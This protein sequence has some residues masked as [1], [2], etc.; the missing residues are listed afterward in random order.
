MYAPSPNDLLNVWERGTNKPAFQKALLLLGVAFPQE[1]PDGLAQLS[2]G[3]RN[4]RLLNLREQL[5]GA[6]FQS[7]VTCPRCSECLDLSFK[8]VD[9]RA[10]PENEPAESLALDV[11]DYAMRF[12]LPTS[13]DLATV[14]GCEDAAA[15]RRA[16]LERCLLSA[17]RK[18]IA[19]TVDDLPAEVLK[20]IDE[21]MEE[22]DPQ[23]NTQLSM[24]CP[25]CGYHWQAV[26]DLVTYVWRELDAW[27]RRALREVH[28]LAS[29]YGWS[30]HEILNM[31]PWRRRIYMEMID[32]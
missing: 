18:G 6:H 10:A 23:A 17:Y 2:V 16:L 21:A 22:V 1:S 28:S 12:R 9:I 32:R 31:R 27:A 5:F 30:E 13:T 20:R 24:K 14:V 3:Q 8:T 19:V 29:V 15:V 4:A 25:A 26:L 11:A 7:V